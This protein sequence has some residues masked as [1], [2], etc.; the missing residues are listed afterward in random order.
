MGEI[1]TG[2]AGAVETARA[3]LT[4]DLD[5]DI[6]VVGAGLAGLTVALEAA[7]LGASVVVL[8]DLLDL[9]DGSDHAVSSLGVR[10]KTLTVARV[11]DPDELS[12][13]F[14]GPL[15]LR[16]ME[17]EARVETDAAAAR[18]R[19]LAALEAQAHRW[20]EQLLNRGG[21]LVS[22][23]TADDPVK[24]VRKVLDALGGF[25]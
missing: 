15:H 10:G 5:A 8:S 6:C 13:P 12:F 18:P 9:P 21:S 1:L 23:N 11:L 7:R 16:A 20:S 4:F 19:Y 25:G 2:T 17:G 14:T 3:R 22:L 24:S